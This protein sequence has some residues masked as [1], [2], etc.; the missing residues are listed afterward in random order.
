MPQEPAY[1]TSTFKPSAFYPNKR[2]RMELSTRCSPVF[3]PRSSVASPRSSHNDIPRR[4]SY[5]PEEQG[6]SR[7]AWSDTCQQA[8]REAVDSRSRTAYHSYRDQAPSLDRSN[9]AES[10]SWS[11]F[12]RTADGRSPSGAQGH[13]SAGDPSRNLYKLSRPR[14]ESSY[15]DLAASAPFRVA[16]DRAVHSSIDERDHRLHEGPRAVGREHIAHVEMAAGFAGNVYSDRQAAFFMPSHYDYQQGK[17]RKRSNLP[18]QSTEIM[19]T[20]FD[21]VCGIECPSHISAYAVADNVTEYIESLPKRGAKAD[22]LQCKCQLGKR[23]AHYADEHSR[24][25]ASA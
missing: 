16:Q 23:L 17:T 7:R 12:G 20:W 10:H 4:S 24:Q 9:P 25:P 14:Q 6:A 18:K 8:Q 15:S 2:P 19:K 22:L 5:R 21:Q 11:T 3:D 1:V 13:C